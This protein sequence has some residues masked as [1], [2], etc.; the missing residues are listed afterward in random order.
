MRKIFCVILLVFL[1]SSP[2]TVFGFSVLKNISAP[3]TNNFSL[4]PV[5]LE[6]EINE[7]AVATK[8]IHIFNG[9]GV[10]SEF[11]IE[12]ED[13]YSDENISQPNVSKF[14]RYV[15]VD[16]KKFILEQGE[17]AT[18]IVSVRVPEGNR[19][20]FVSGAILVSRRGLKD[21]ASNGSSVTMRSGALVFIDIGKTAIRSGYLNKFNYVGNGVFSV[22]FKNT[23]ESKL[24]PYGYI[25]FKDFWG[26]L[27]G[28]TTIEPWF[29]LPGTERSINVKWDIPSKLSPMYKAHLVLYPGYGGGENTE[30]TSI[31]IYNFYSL[32]ATASEPGNLLLIGSLYL[33]SP[34][35]LIIIFIKFFQYVKK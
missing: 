5:K 24:N 34:I 4:S 13:M 26:R 33:L 32:S 16:N 27:A 10:T 31:T 2:T 3:V 17:E 1:M 7:G 8:E 20:K 18:V 11:G 19:D 29:V 12:F 23:G 35:F 25:E 15:S 9:S 14:S 30:N 28:K 21:I 6:F 22:H